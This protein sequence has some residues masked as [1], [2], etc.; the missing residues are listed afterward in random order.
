VGPKV[1]PF[2]VSRTLGYWEFLVGYWILNS[3]Y[4]PSVNDVMALK[5]VNDVVAVI[6]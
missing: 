5:C 3:S 6:S 4:I 2:S 1:L